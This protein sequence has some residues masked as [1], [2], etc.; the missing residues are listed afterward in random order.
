MARSTTQRS[1][2]SEGRK[3]SY[4]D[5]SAGALAVL[6]AGPATRP[7]LTLLEFFLG[8]SD[9]TLSGGLPLGVIDP[10][11]ELVARQRRDVSPR[12]QRPGVGQQC[13]TQVGGKL[14]HYPAG[15]RVTAHGARLIAE[16]VKA[17]TLTWVS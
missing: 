1:N 5:L 4:A 2:H 13:R 9:P 12:S 6:A 16:L 10:A 17:G 11:D 3:E 7:A 14:V 8:A 15:H